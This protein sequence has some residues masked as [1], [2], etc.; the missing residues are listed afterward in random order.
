MGE[1]R[2][3][4]QSAS[5]IGT[6][7]LLSKLTQYVLGLRIEVLRGCFEMGVAKELLERR[8]RNAVSK[9]RDRECVS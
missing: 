8:E 9:A 6:A 5:P 3:S 2:K 7:P 4:G 1:A